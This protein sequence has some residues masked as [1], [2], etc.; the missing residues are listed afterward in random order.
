MF[1]E[2][3][4]AVC[5]FGAALLQMS[6]A[7]EQDKNSVIFSKSEGGGGAPPRR[8]KAPRGGVRGAASSPLPQH[9]N[10]RA[11]ASLARPAAPS[12]ELG[13]PSASPS[14]H[15]TK[16]IREDD[17]DNSADEIISGRR[18]MADV[19]INELKPSND[20]MTQRGS[21]D[22]ELTLSL[23]TSMISGAKPEEVNRCSTFDLSS[24]DVGRDCGAPLSSPCFDL[25]RCVNGPSIYVYDYEVRYKITARNYLLQNTTRSYKSASAVLLLLFS[26]LLFS[27]LRCD[28]SPRCSKVPTAAS[29]VYLM[30]SM[31]TA[32]AAAAVASL[33]QEHENT[34]TC[35]EF[36][37]L[38][39]QYVYCCWYK[40]LTGT[41]FCC[42]CV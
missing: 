25:S 6:A 22:E 31:R 42:T 35:S 38:C 11:E 12:R 14:R 3:K 41:K 17:D 13:A 2:R 33:V 27:H 8:K 24:F 20:E 30:Q 28:S 7:T 5:F 10:D 40:G 23:G 1:S 4:L 36:T 15:L 16:F 37:S 18:R 39:L 29:V 26:Q 19:D 21:S 32:A 9:H 34:R